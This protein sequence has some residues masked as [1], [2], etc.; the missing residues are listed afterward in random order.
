MGLVDSFFYEDNFIIIMTLLNYTLLIEDSCILA[1]KVHW[2]IIEHC[3]VFKSVLL[4][5][6]YLR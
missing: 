4:K 1:H 5:T 2:T 3:N 6:E